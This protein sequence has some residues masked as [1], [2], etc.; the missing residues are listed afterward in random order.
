MLK[1]LIDSFAVNYF[2][3]N[4]QFKLLLKLMLVKNIIFNNLFKLNYL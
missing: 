4:T 2:D 1:V 3:D